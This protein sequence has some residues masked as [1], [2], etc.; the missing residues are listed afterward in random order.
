M[1][2]IAGKCSG[3]MKINESQF[4]HCF[5]EGFVRFYVPLDF[6][7]AEI[8]KNAVQCLCIILKDISNQ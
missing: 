5:V 3:E 8:V 1:V 6:V 4:D 2:F 7:W